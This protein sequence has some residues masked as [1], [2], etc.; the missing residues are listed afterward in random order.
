MMTLMRDKISGKREE[1][2]NVF[3]MMRDASNIIRNHVYTSDIQLSG[4]FSTR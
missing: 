4:Q 1:K 2:D 3:K